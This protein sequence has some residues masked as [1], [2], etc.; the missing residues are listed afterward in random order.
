MLNKLEFNNLVSTRK[1]FQQTTFN[2]IFATG[3]FQQENNTE[4]T[5][6]NNC[7]ASTEVKEIEKYFDQETGL[8]E[9]QG[10]AS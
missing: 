8:C 1:Q 9:T 10:K 5:C 6:T 4:S 7:E 3:Y 2:K